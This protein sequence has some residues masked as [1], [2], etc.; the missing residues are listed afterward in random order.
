MGLQSPAH[1]LAAAAKSPNGSP[2]NHNL[3]DLQLGAD[4]R[5]LGIRP[6][7]ARLDQQQDPGP[8]VGHRL[9]LLGLHQLRPQQS[10][11]RLSPSKAG[12]ESPEET[13]ASDQDLLGWI[14]NKIRA[15]TSATALDFSG[16]IS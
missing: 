15:R 14:N 3:N 4:Q 9:G 2:G 11:Q 13:S 6:G 12:A 10:T 7:P 16:S 1:R 8:H 5:A